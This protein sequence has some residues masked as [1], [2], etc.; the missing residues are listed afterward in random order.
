MSPDVNQWYASAVSLSNG[1]TPETPAMTARPAPLRFT[2]PLPYGAIVHD[3]GVQ[4]V[5]FSRSAG[6][7]RV[8]LYKR[9]SDGEP[10]EIIDFDPELNRWGDIWS[11]FV[12]GVGPG[13]LYHFQADGPHEPDRGQRFDPQAR[14]ID[15]Y[16]K[17]LAGRFL[18]AEGGSEF[19][20]KALAEEG[21]SPADIDTVIYT[22]LHN[23]HAGSG[24]L[25]TNATFVFQKAEWQNLL[26]PLPVQSIRGD[27]DPDVIDALSGKRIL[28]IAGDL[29][30]EEGIRLIKT[31]GHSLGSQSIAVNT[32]QGTVVLVGDLCL[33]NFMMFPGTREIMD[34]EGNLFPI[35][36]APPIFGPALPHSL[37]YDFYTYYD[38]IHKVKATAEKD[39]PGYIICGHEPSLVVTGIGK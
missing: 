37:I 4:F 14:L 33:F 32:E 7:M 35:P 24:R 13:Q 16:A 29:Q 34:M 22:H 19:L 38:S 3:G 36:P 20:I 21:L 2:H 39:A 15:P 28:R 11:V 23:D 31:P 10:A 12:P 18:P 1:A 27:Y 8:L 5:V 25:F 17:A 6:A 30:L 9:A 26:D